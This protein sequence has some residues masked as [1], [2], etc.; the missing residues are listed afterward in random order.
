MGKL[1]YQT[2]MTHQI[3]SWEATE[4][5]NK[6]MSSVGLMVSGAR[7]GIFRGWSH[8]LPPKQGM[9]YV[10]N[11][12]FSCF[13][14]CTHALPARVLMCVKTR[15]T[16]STRTREVEFSIAWEFRKIESKCCP[17]CL[18]P[19]STMA[20]TSAHLARVVATPF[21]SFPP[22]QIFGHFF[23]GIRLSRELSAPQ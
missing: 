10:F 4:H 2:A 21:G 7:H 17:R 18:N 20:N 3:T 22:I 5:K 6:K 9:F 19:I 1:R 12:C 11:V 8:L 23:E 16:P 13:K 15:I 14:L